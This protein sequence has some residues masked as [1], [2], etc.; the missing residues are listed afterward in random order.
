MPGG[1]RSVFS[2]GDPSRGA[3]YPNIMQHHS[4][5]AYVAHTVTANFS[6]DDFGGWVAPDFNGESTAFC[7]EPFID[8]GHEIGPDSRPLTHR[9]LSI[10]NFNANYHVK[11][12]APIIA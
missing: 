1:S 12:L 3:L 11:F 7:V 4:N 8:A 2:F 5:V 10:M 6:F 9:K